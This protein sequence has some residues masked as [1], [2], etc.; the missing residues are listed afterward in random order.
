M[1]RWWVVEGGEHQRVSEKMV[2]GGGRRASEG[3]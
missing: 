3:E 1:R 2:G